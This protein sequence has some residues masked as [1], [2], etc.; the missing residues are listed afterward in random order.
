MFIA[1]FVREKGILSLE[2]AIMKITSKPAE[3]MKINDRGILKVG[4]WAD[5]TIFDL[6]RIG[7]RG[8]YLEPR[9]PPDGIEYVIVN[10]EIVLDRGKHSGALS[11]KVIRKRKISK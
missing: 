2:E 1:K 7:Y 6:N 4:A 3:R 11:G 10:G 8:T 9:V 5:I